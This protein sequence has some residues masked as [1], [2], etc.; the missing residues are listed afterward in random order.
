MPLKN[1][2]VLK[3]RPIA[4]RFGSGKSPHYQVH[5]VADGENYR[6]AINVESAD[7]SEVEFLV[8]SRF[9]HPITDE[10]K[11][12]ADG[13]HPQ[14]PQ[15]NSVALD[16]IR[17]NLLQPQEM[18]PLPLTAPGP[19]NDLNEKLDQFVQRALSNEDAMIYAFGETWGPETKAD[20]TSASSR[21]AA[22]T[23]ST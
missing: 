7:G 19:D 6:I 4:M 2:S 20:K 8:R 21:A 16:Y 9:V 17:G 1:Y 5:L 22:F 11:G 18:A 15:P 10:L 13:L 23:T 12:L 14:P 3:G